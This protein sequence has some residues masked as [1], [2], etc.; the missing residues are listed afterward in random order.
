[1]EATIERLTERALEAVREAT[2]GDVEYREVNSFELR[3]VMTELA[4]DGA[5]NE[6][7]GNG[8]FDG[9]HLND[10]S[11]RTIAKILIRDYE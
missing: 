9:V 4:E 11:D 6:Y 3:R 8:I 10:I 5:W 7:E 2:G 1:M